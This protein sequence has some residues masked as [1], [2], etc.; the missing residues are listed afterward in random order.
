MNDTMRET[1]VANVL[2]IAATLETKST[3]CYCGVGCGVI[4]ESDGVQV[5]G[6][7]GD[8]DH[9]A[10]FGKLCSKGSNLHLS[11]KPL[12]QQQVRA[13]Y[14]ESRT[15]RTQTRQRIDWDSCLDSM[16]DKFA[17]T[18]KEHGPDSVGFYISGQ[19]LTEDYYVFNKLAKGLIGTNNIDSNSRLCMSS[20]VAGYKQTLG[21]DAPPCSYEDIDHTDLLFIAGSNT[22][23]AHPILYRRI[24]RAREKNPNLKMIVVD[25]RRTDT[26][27]D[28]DLH[29]AILPGTDVA[30]FNGLLHLCL[31]DDTLD[32]NFITQH[33]DGFAELKKTVRDFTPT[34]VAQ[35]C[36]IKELDLHQ[37]AQWFGQA[38]AALSLYCQGLNQSAAGTAKN[39]ALI[40]LHL[41]TGQI[42]NPGAGPFSLTGQPNAMGGREVG[43]MAN[44]L[45][46]HRDLSNPDHRAEVA[47][48]WGVDNVPAQPG[49]TAVELF[50]AVR[51]G[52]IKLLWIVCTNPAQSMPDQNLI[53]E[54]LLK[55]ELVIVQ[56]AYASTA[57]VPYADILLPASTWSEKSGTVTNSERR[58]SRVNAAIDAPGEARHDWEIAAQF[59]QKLALKLNKSAPFFSYA[60][61]EEIWN[62]HRATTSG[63]DL[64][65]TG[66]SYDILQTQGPQ[67]WPYHTGASTGK[68]RLYEDHQFATVNGRARFVNTRYMPTVEKTNPRYP[69]A[70][71]TGRLRDH[72]HGMS[73]TGTVAQLFAHAAEP[74][75]EMAAQDM[76]RRFIKNGDLVEV[77]NGRG[78]Q[79]LIASASDTLKAGQA[80]IAMHWGEEFVSGAV[81]NETNK[82]HTSYGVNTLCNP[83]IDP[84]S[85]QPELKHTAVKIVKAECPWQFLVIAWLDEAKILSIQQGLRQFYGKFAYASCVPFGRDKQGL[86]FRAAHTSA[87]DHDI[88]EQIECLMGIHGAAVLRYDDKKRGNSRHLLLG[89]NEYGST[90]QAIALA[91][92]I[93]AEHWLRVLIDDQT[94]IQQTKSLLL[95]EAPPTQDVNM[96]RDKIIC[97]CL[98][99]G[100]RQIQSEIKK[101]NEH[102]S[103]TKKDVLQHLK[104]RLRCGTNCG[105]CVPEIKQMILQRPIVGIQDSSKLI[106][107]ISDHL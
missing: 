54:A 27:R 63:R 47:A 86:L 14:P 26:A 6:V 105:S 95:N 49:K 19:L 89:Q 77:S 84:D 32:H 70:L 59:A 83:T 71:T 92:D 88:T 106:S 8:P 35:I 60:S 101:L 2:D 41:A 85:K 22:A 61:P 67:Q 46:G 44:L 98:N 43:G 7:R 93:S 72:W 75:I 66:L 40:N 104:Q 3:C 51:Q 12:L 64:D 58:I 39:A 23:F 107:K 96:V 36:G 102:F 57:T 48:L 80:F 78:M 11:A 34:M 24:E 5:T 68:A 18:I 62:E 87:V 65:I 73:R 33:T 13:L 103:D 56:D 10:N 82:E 52:D 90:L 100:E 81:S 94:S 17:A 91:G 9:P 4:I 20:A 37:A 25:P 79:R 38:K 21:S 99:V 50:E 28:A 29:L 42:G 55:A 30:L 53:R 69:F 45:S 74:V 31:W 1:K 16:V 97:T 15:D 76:E